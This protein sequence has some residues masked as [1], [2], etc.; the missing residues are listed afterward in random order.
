[1]S[2]WDDGAAHM[3]WL[4]S[5]YPPDR[6]PSEP[7]VSRGSC[8]PDSGDPGEVED[9]M[10]KAKVMQNCAA[11][12][13]DL[14]PLYLGYIF[15]HQIWTSWLYLPRHWPHQLPARAHHAAQRHNGINIIQDTFR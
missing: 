8:S 13:T 12:K 5:E 15:R 14:I 6:D 10:A 1:M 3:L 9:I 11:A 4:D 2:L 7:G